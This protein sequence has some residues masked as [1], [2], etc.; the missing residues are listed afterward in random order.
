MMKCKKD[1]YTACKLEKTAKNQE[2]NARN[3]TEVSP[4]QVRPYY[5]ISD[6]CTFAKLWIFFVVFERIL[7]DREN[8]I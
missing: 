8:C 1:Y 4:D 2:N 6:L 7:T 5:S 3:S